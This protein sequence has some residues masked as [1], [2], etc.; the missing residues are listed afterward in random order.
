MGGPQVADEVVKEEFWGYYLD[1]AQFLHPRWHVVEITSTSTGKKIAIHVAAYLYHGK[2][3]VVTKPI[4]YSCPVEEAIRTY[5]KR[6]T[7]DSGY[8]EKHAFQAVTSTR[9]W[10]VRLLLFVISVLL[11]NT[12]RL[13]PAWC[14]LLIKSLPTP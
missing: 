7:I 11:W 6:F 8:K 5:N 14:F 1:P 13:A 3:K 2:M 4:W 10:A 12:W 9:S